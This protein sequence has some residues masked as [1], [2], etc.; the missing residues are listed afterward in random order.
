[1]SLRNVTLEM[2]LKPFFDDS[3]AT[4]RRVCRRLFTQ[5]LPLLREAEQVSVLLWCADGSEIL[6]YRGDL[7]APFEWARYIGGA[8]PREPVA[9]DPEGVDLHSRSYLYREQ[10]AVFTYG[11]LKRLVGWLKEEGSAITGKP[12]RVGETFDPGPEFAVSPF[13]YQRHNEVCLGG[14]MGPTSFLCCYGRLHADDVPYAGFPEGIPEGLPVGTFLGRQCRHFLSDLGFDYLWLSNGF[15]FGSETWALRGVLFDTEA[16]HPERA[17]DAGRQNLEFWDLFRKECPDV[18]LEVRGTNLT[19]AVDLAS[20]AVP[21]REIYRGGYGIQPPPNSPWAALNGDFGIELVGWMSHIAELPADTFPYRFYTHDP[22]WLNSPWLDRY[23]REPHDIYLPLSVARLDDAGGVH[24][25]TAIEFLTADNSYGEMP[26]QVPNEVIPHILAARADAPDAPGPLVW[27][28]PFDEYHDWTFQEPQRLEEVFFGDWLVRGAVNRG[29]PLNTVISTRALAALLSSDAAALVRSVLVSPVPAA[30]G[31]WEAALFRH[32]DAGGQAL[33]YGPITL[34]SPRLRELLGLRP[35]EPIEGE[36][37]IA[38]RLPG[39][40]LREGG[41]GSTAVHRAL[42]CGGGLDA[43]ATAASEVLATVGAGEQERAAAVLRR[44]AGGTV[45]WVR[46]TVACGPVPKRGHLLT[47]LDARAAY[48][49]EMLLRLLLGEMGTSIRF[50]KRDAG[51]PD[52]MLCVARHANAW[53]LSGFC[54]DTTV[55]Q[56]LRFP[57]GAPLLLGFETELEEGHSTYTLPRAWHRECRVFVEQARPAL[58]SCREATHEQIGLK[59]RFLVTGLEDATVRFFPDPGHEG[60]TTFLRDPQFPFV[61][62]DFLTP[63][64]YDDARGRYLGVGGVSG[65]LLISW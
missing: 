35:A 43:V 2:S 6:D 14:T 17:A 62:G 56:H 37:P 50:E 24:T 36:F 13:K 48:P 1:M 54:P 53:Y 51:R 30:D 57:A 27:V 29:L 8:N 34:A 20:D 26:D 40:R 22:W 60:R 18:P 47:P 64:L 4:A 3:E 11:W 10:P 41:Y 63:T 23:G 25:P 31:P 16:F 55:R 9:G 45:G 19:T 7:D 61:A 58:L 44:L 65:S 12:V 39:D 38:V 59:R 46:G 33:L 15:G 32:L 28:Y 21:L 49:T 5:W 42:V 52:P